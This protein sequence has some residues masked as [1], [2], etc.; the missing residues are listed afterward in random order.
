L[1]EQILCPTNHKFQ[2]IP[3]PGNVPYKH[4][5]HFCKHNPLPPSSNSEST[6]SS[7]LKCELKC[8]AGAHNVNPEDLLR[9]ISSTSGK[10]YT[11][12]TR[13]ELEGAGLAGGVTPT[14]LRKESK[15][16]LE[17]LEDSRKPTMFDLRLEDR[18]KIANLICKL[19]QVQ[20][21]LEILQEQRS[22]RTVNKSTWTEG[23]E[24]DQKLREA[25]RQNQL[26]SSKVAH[27]QDQNTSLRN[28]GELL[29]QKLNRYSK[30]NQRLKWILRTIQEREEILL[31]N[32]LSLNP[33][34][35]SPNKTLL[36]PTPLAVSSHPYVVNETTQTDSNTVKSRAEKKK[37][38]DET[39]RMLQSGDFHELELSDPH[40]VIPSPTKPIIM[41]I[42]AGDSQGIQPSYTNWHEQT[43]TGYVFSQQKESAKPGKQSDEEILEELFFNF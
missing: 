7:E 15:K 23:P 12:E 26:L 42:P 8:G 22:V 13:R 43:N 3:K 19:A 37:S 36:N 10:T 40:L 33:Q 29:E 18:K 34:E 2:P 16:L 39:H 14:S 24:C 5:E 41:K 25:L 11:V 4:Q 32:S 21:Q 30:D 35:S 20:E 28:K 38:E 6:L 31:H 17:D 9:S 1:A 27:L